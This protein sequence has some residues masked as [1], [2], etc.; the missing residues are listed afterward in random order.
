[1]DDKQGFRNNEVFYECG[2]CR[3]CGGPLKMLHYICDVN[4]CAINARLDQSLVEKFARWAHKGTP[5]E[6]LLIAGLPPPA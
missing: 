1:M 4:V 5:R 2:A 3:V 6:V